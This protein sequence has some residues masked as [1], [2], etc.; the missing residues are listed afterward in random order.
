MVTLKG[1]LNVKDKFTNDEQL[2][3]QTFL[4]QNLSF[5]GYIKQIVLAQI[6]NLVKH[7][8]KRHTS[9]SFTI[10]SQNFHVFRFLFKDH[11][12]KYQEQKIR[13]AAATSAD[14]WSCGFTLKNSLFLCKWPKLHFHHYEHLI[15]NK[16]QL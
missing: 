6:A 8:K 16:A 11:I 5:S 4:G 1:R 3:S 10:L 9:I 12:A 13:N 7:Y 15:I 14:V 2:N